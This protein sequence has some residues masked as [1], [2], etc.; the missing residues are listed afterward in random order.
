MDWTKPI[1]E[2]IVNVSAGR[3]QHIITEVL[4]AIRLFDGVE[5][6][7]VDI[8]LA[9]DRTVFTLIGEIN[10]IFATIKE[11]YSLSHK[12]I[13][14]FAYQGNHP[15]V[16][17]IDVVPFVALKN[18]TEEELALK[19]RKFAQ[20]I[21]S[22][23][24]VAICF[25]CK[26]ALS[27]DQFSLS[28]IRKGGVLGAQ[29]RVNRG[30]LKLDMGSQLHETLGL[31]CWTVRKFMVAYNVNLTTKDI[32]LAKKIAS[33]IRRVRDIDRNTNLQNV[34][35]I[36]WYVPEYDCCQISTNLYDIAQCDMSQLFELVK[37]VAKDIG[38]ATH[39]SELIGMTPLK[40]LSSDSGFN[41]YK[42]VVN[43]L[44]LGMVSTFIPEE[45]I[46]ELKLGLDMAL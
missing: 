38:V 25:Y 16:G 12:R 34:K 37:D 33:A 36:G 19:V 9:A 26:M 8:G 39:G 14:V 27:N 15:T 35:V 28:Q 4:D 5:L 30:D 22:E 32:K 10:E 31:S 1:V 2:C 3:Q 43:K 29:R 23:Y 40:G 41:N 7:H 21:F 13:N 20:E 44:G 11:L 17:A 46:L 24:N 6:L 18:I 42:E 45:R